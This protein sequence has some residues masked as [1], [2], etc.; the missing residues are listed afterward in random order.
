MALRQEAVKVNGVRDLER[1]ITL[2]LGITESAAALLTE[3]R[4]SE[5]VPDSYG[6]RIFGESD[7]QGQL[8]VRLAFT[9]EPEEGDAVLD[10]QGT[11]LFVAPEVTA[12]LEESLI[13]VEQVGDRAAL[14][15]RSQG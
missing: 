13:D 11:Q 1:G 14:V 10:Q 4:Q 8:Q 3:A 15:I 7:P 5:G 9:E 6:V 2:M 12:P